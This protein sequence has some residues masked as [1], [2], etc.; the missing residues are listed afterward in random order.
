MARKTAA[1]WPWRKWRR[2]DRRARR[3][4]G[5]RVCHI[6]LWR[7]SLYRTL[8]SSILL[9]WQ[10]AGLEHPPLHSRQRRAASALTAGFRLTRALLQPLLAMTVA[11]ADATC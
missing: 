1:H 9:I 3:G 6:A 8:I 2:G 7:A 5:D 4:R 11:N 10:A